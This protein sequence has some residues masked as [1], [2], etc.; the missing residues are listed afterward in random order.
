MKNK[1]NMLVKRHPEK[2]YLVGDF[3]ATKLNKKDFEE[4]KGL[5]KDLL[6]KHEFVKFE[7]TDFSWWSKTHQQL[8]KTKLIKN[9]VFEKDYYG[10]ITKY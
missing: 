10:N 8:T 7:D 5:N 9:L 3:I 1:Y 2:S 6:G 4:L